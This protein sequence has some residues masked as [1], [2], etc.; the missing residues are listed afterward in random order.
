MSGVMDICECIRQSLRRQ[1][2]NVAS[3]LQNAN[4]QDTISHGGDGTGILPSQNEGLSPTILLSMLF[5]FLFF[6]VLM[7]LRRPSGRN[8]EKPTPAQPNNQGPPAPP[9][10]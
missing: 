4:Q 10:D 1:M 5:V 8:L 3:I 7:S 6:M 2:E 9:V